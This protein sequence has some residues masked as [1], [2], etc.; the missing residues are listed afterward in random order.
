MQISDIDVRHLIYS[1]FAETARPPTVAEVAENFHVSIASI[2]AAF[3]RLG[4][5]HHIALAPGTYSIWMAHPFSGV[6]TD[7][8]AEVGGKKYWGN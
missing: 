6:P 3:E 1:T 5:D 7:F 4:K 2:E 8:V